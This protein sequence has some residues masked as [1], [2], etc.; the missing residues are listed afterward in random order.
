MAR[1]LTSVAADVWTATA[2][3]WTSLTTIVVAPDGGCLIVDPGITVQEIVELADELDARGWHVDAAFSTHPHWDHVLWHVRLGDAPRWAT[4]MAVTS[5]DATRVADLVK[6]DAAA[7]GHDPSQFGRLIAVP[8]DADAVPWAGPR[9]VVVPHRAHARGHAGLVLPEQHVLI[10]GDMLSDLEIPLLDV[11]AA[12]P[13]GDYRSALDQLEAAAVAADV[14][15]VIPG[16]GHVGDAAELARRLAADRSY[17]DAL[18][19]GRPPT[20]ARLTTLWLAAE[21]VRHVDAVE[22]RRGQLAPD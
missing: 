20:D 19:A 2:E 8:D 22:R 3:I 10:A 15:T 7:P 16:H 11:D 6:V 18:D 13:V 1:E 14:R 21:H 4:A 5:Q 12:D 9:A 17:L